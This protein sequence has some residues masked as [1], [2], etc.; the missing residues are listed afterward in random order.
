MIQLEITPSY[1][2]FGEISGEVRRLFFFIFFLVFDKSLNFDEISFLF[3]L[4]YAL[5]LLIIS[6]IDH[7]ID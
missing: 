5:K 4:K 3:I 1:I 6:K 2:D 7:S